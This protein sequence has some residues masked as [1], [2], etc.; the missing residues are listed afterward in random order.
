MTTTPVEPFQ[1]E[2]NA[3]LTLRAKVS[4]LERMQINTGI[5]LSLLE[6]PD[7]RHTLTYMNHRMEKAKRELYLVRVWYGNTKWHPEPQ[8]LLR[9]FDYAKNAYRDFAVADFEF[10]DTSAGG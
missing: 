10:T 9:A 8:L 1:K 2:V 3:A 6:N 4:R 7:R 5:I